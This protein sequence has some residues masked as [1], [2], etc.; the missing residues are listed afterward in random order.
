MEHPRVVCSCVDQDDCPTSADESSGITTEDSDPIDQDRSKPEL[1]SFCL[2]KYVEPEGNATFLAVWRSVKS[3]SDFSLGQEPATTL[4]SSRRNCDI[5]LFKRGN[6]TIKDDSSDDEAEDD[7]HTKKKLRSAMLHLDIEEDRAIE[8]T[9]RRN[10]FDGERIN[11]QLFHM[12]LVTSDIMNRVNRAHEN[13]QVCGII[14]EFFFGAVDKKLYFSA[15]LGIHWENSPSSWETLRHEDAISRMICEFYESE[16]RPISPRRPLRYADIS[17][18]TPSS[19]QSRRGRASIVEENE[20]LQLYHE[21]NPRFPS[22]QL[23]HVNER[24]W[25]CR[26]ALLPPDISPRYVGAQVPKRYRCG[27]FQPLLTSKQADSV[28]RL[29]LSPRAPRMA[30]PLVP[31]PQQKSSARPHSFVHRSESSQQYASSSSREMEVR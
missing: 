13:R 24:Q 31:V 16:K 8:R 23:P 7:E 12:K 19:P 11:P 27:L 4:A 20:S 22:V 26:S 25:K 21:L 2:Q 5:F 14:C 1:R 15:L 6:Y 30:R 9:L 3:R 18:S 28:N 10:G 29:H 17:N